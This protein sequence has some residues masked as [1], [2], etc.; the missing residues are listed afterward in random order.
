V[1]T[2]SA[3]VDVGGSSFFAKSSS[4]SEVR[5]PSRSRIYHGHVVGPCAGTRRG[6]AGGRRPPDP[7]GRRG[8]IWA[9]LGTGISDSKTSSATSIR[10][11]GSSSAVVNDNSIVLP[12]PQ[13]PGDR[14]RQPGPHTRGEQ[15]RHRHGHPFPLHQLGQ[16]TERDPGELADVDQHVPAAGDVA[17][18]D[19]DAGPSSRRASCNP[20]RTASGSGLFGAVAP[21][22]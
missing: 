20:G 6:R 11:D 12:D 13:R 14:D 19:V 3:V 1:S 2:A 21:G 4:L 15:I 22:D 5:N 7:P 18:H 8:C 17:V 10:R 16:R 9:T